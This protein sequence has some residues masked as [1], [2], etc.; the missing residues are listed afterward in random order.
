MVAE[1]QTAGRGRLGRRFHSPPY[2]NLY[3]SIV[4]RPELALPDAPAWTLASAV[5]VAD[6]SPTAIGDDEARSRSSGP[7]TC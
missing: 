4:L 7:T 1:G 6:A 3:T 2:L 5:A